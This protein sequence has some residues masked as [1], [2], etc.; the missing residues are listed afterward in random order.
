MVC[1]MGWLTVVSWFISC[2]GQRPDRRWGPPSL[3]FNR[4]WRLFPVGKSSRCM[5]LSLT[6]IQESGQECVEL[7]FHLC[8]HCVDMNN[9]TFS[10]ALTDMPTCW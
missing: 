1:L 8:L 3:A 10:L 2:Q 5:K 6:Y 4:Y 7:Y 9:F